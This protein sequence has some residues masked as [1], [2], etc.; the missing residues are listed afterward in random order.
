[1][2]IETK[3]SY[4][5]REEFNELRDKER[6]LEFKAVIGVITNFMAMPLYMLF[7]LADYLYVPHLFW[8]FF[9]VRLMILPLAFAV[10]S[11]VQRSSSFSRIQI[12]ALIFTLGMSST[13]NYMIFRI[14][15][16][17]TLYYAGLNL[18]S[19]GTLA[20][21]PW[22]KTMLLVA[23]AGI[24]LPYYG[25]AM[26]SADGYS[27]LNAVVVNSF[28]VV[29]TLVIL[30]VTRVFNERL[31]IRK[32]RSSS[33]LIE[34][35]RGRDEVI[36]EKAAEAVKLSRLS[37]QFSPQVVEAIQDG[38]IDIDKPAFRSKICAI[39][40]DIVG[41]TEGVLRLNQ[42]RVDQVLSQFMDDCVTSFLKYDLT[43]DKFMGDGIL[44]FSNHPVKHSDFV[45]RAT[46]AAL[47]AREAITENCSFYHTRWEKEFSVYFGIAIGYANVGFYGSEKFFKTYTA[48]GA[49]MAL[50]SRLSDVADANQILVDSAVAQVLEEQDFVLKR[51]DQ[52]TLKGFE[53]QNIQIFE[54]LD[55]PPHLLLHSGSLKCPNCL[56]SALYLHSSERGIVD[57][58]CRLCHHVMDGL[59]QK[60]RDDIK[61][62]S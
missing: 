21:I 48:I 6:V 13:I 62:A 25:I 7:S 18:I 22:S 24:Y 55:A 47:E 45:E 12:F 54:V 20:F 1:M 29:G 5:S 50:A 14:G 9:V 39:F 11:L 8:E 3:K 35:I 38:K 52:I 15:D 10:N 42:K 59:R 60:N 36:K 17:D 46:L 26:S 28:F 44:A 2:S 40:V 61:K 41:S 33:Q 51:K 56:E 27:D 4:F 43:I 49:P 31:R 30:Y 16:V 23:I 58:R 34:E 37:N 57:F 32:L 19:I 53:D